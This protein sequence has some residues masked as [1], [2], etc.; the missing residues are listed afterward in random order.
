MP[1]VSKLSNPDTKY[2]NWDAKYSTQAWG[3]EYFRPGYNIQRL[4]ADF[5]V[6]FENFSRE[7]NI[8][9]RSSKSWEPGYENVEPDPKTFA[10][11]GTAYQ[12]ALAKWPAKWPDWVKPS[13]FTKLLSLLLRGNTEVKSKRM[14]PGQSRTADTYVVEIW[15]HG[16]SWRRR[17]SRENDFRA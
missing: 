1:G 10:T 11:D 16:I 2:S 12:L 17:S 5:E 9:R 8:W 14:P 3:Y 15:E 7:L 13:L 4:V 6:G